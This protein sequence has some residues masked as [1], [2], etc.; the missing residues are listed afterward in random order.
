MKLSVTALNSTMAWLPAP[1]RLPILAGLIVFLVAVATTQIALAV[2]NRESDRQIELMARVYLDG[3]AAAIAENVANGAWRDVERRFSAAF[4]EQQGIEEV[5]LYILDSSGEILAS[6]YNRPPVHSP[7]IRLSA[8][9]MSFTVDQDSQLAWASRTIGPDNSRRLVAALDL[10]PIWASRQQLLLIVIAI[11]LLI[12]FV[13]AILAFMLLRRINRPAEALLALTQEA[14]QG[15]RRPV[16][17][18]YISRSDPELRKALLA[19]NAMIEGLEERE[20]LRA[21]IAERSQAS[22]LGRLAATLAH[23]VRNPLGGLS[24]AV[25]TIRKF[26]DDQNVRNESL[27]FI[28]RGIDSIESMVTRMLNIQ[29][30]AEERRLTRADFE[31]LRLLVRPVIA[32]RRL[33]LDWSINLPECFDVGAS[34]VRQVLLNLLLNACTAS[35]DGGTIR[36]AA[37][38]EGSSLVCIVSDEGSGMESARVDQLLGLKPADSGGRRLGLDAVVSLLGE[39]DASASVETGPRGGTVVRISIPVSVL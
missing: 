23:E 12:A 38:I 26:G 10:T 22:A 15:L 25:A 33:N 34:G 13:C 31:D 5:A 4:D 32:K 20:K 30:P 6:A 24:T 39:L 36:L 17:E 16:P 14:R 2:A 18:A 1:L 7:S 9:R 3:L 27:D 28:A 35:P 19:Y 11:D 21:D 37:S 29:R 8:Q